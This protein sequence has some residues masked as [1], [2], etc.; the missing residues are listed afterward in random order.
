MIHP[1]Q[2]RQRSP[3]LIRALYRREN[4]KSKSYSVA[5]PFPYFVYADVTIEY[6]Y[7]ARAWGRRRVEFVSS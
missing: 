1:S 3:S 2:K 7:S 6:K 4:P 5:R